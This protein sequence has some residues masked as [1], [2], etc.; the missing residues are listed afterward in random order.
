[1]TKPFQGSHFK[2]VCDYIMGMTSIKKAK[3]PSTSKPTVTKKDNSVKVR[4]FE[5]NKTAKKWVNPS[6]VGVLA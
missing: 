2:R 4:L 1:M 5:R 3:N 6:S